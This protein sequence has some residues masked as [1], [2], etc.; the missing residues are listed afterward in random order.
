MRILNVF[1]K[2]ALWLAVAAI[3]II[4]L[5]CI[6]VNSWAWVFGLLAI[7]TVLPIDPWQRL[8]KKILKKP[9]KIIAAIAFI[10][11]MFIV[12]F[13]TVESSP[14]E[15]TP[16]SATT[17]AA[18]HAS[19]VYTQTN[20]V[21]KPSE[22]T[23]STSSTTV[24]LTA[25]TEAT[26]AEKT[27]FE[28]STTSVRTTAEPTTIHRHSFKN[29]TC[30][31]PK[32]CSLCGATRGSATGHSFSSGVCQYCG[33]EDPDYYSGVMVWIPKNGEKYHSNPD[34]GNM[35]NPS[36]VPLEK[37]EAMYYTPCSNCY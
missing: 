30:T 22:S 10:L 14:P 18:T 11:A 7:A 6:A 28:E 2:I 21:L 13:L 1:K 15:S 35:R 12:L 4:T 8:L 37:A 20:S 24:A 32:T 23:A 17:S 9:F 5:S 33:T 27:E 36:Q 29:A 26:A 3:G 19:T 34:C 31:S 16:T 25:T